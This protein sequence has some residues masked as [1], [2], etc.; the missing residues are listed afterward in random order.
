MDY[1]QKLCS[2]YTA[3]DKLTC[4]MKGRLMACIM[5]AQWTKGNM[6]DLLHYMFTAVKSFSSSADLLMPVPLSISQFVS[7]VAFPATKDATGDA[8]K[9]DLDTSFHNAAVKVC[10]A[11]VNGTMVS[12]STVILAILGTFC[13]LSKEFGAKKNM[14]ETQKLSIRN[15]PDPYDTRNVYLAGD[16][17]DPVIDLNVVAFLAPLSPQCFDLLTEMLEWAADELQ[18]LHQT[19]NG[20][21]AEQDFAV[22]NA[23][24]ATAA[25]MLESLIEVPTPVEVEDLAIKD[26]I[27]DA[28]FDNTSGITVMGG[29]KI[30]KSTSSSKIHAI[31]DHGFDTGKSYWEFRVS[32]QTWK[33]SFVLFVNWLQ[34]SY[35]CDMYL[36]LPSPF[37]L[38][39]IC[40]LCAWP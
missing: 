1:I 5:G 3:S 7:C 26:I 37:S 32:K 22:P 29:G 39:F 18:A 30:A 40:I 31:V 35:P 27:I 11:R 24:A 21:V 15:I 8:S 4:T 16:V 25:Y 17:E 10:D 28:K 13:A 38:D 36:S 33:L 14:T 12:Y 34:S 19:I 2:K 6:M 23:V 9:S 20:S